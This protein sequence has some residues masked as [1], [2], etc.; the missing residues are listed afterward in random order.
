M[1]RWTYTVPAGRKAD[2][3]S[4]SGFVANASATLLNGNVD[5]Q[6]HYQIS[7][8]NNVRLWWARMVNGEG[9]GVRVL[10]PGRIATMLAGD[11]LSGRHAS[12]NTALGTSVE[13]L[14]GFVATEFDA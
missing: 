10:T 11:A 5:L 14:S 12:A 4:A 6:I 1:D 8:G 9:V 7:G 2:V 13:I 3:E